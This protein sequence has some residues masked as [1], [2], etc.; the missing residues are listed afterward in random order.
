MQTAGKLAE[1]LLSMPLPS[2]LVIALLAVV[3]FASFVIYAVLT[4]ASK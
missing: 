2:L 4:L 1:R 3:A